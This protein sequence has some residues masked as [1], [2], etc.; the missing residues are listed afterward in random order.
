M[1]VRNLLQEERPQT[2]NLIYLSPEA[3]RLLEQFAYEVEG[4]LKNEYADIPDWAG[5]LVGMVLRIAG[6][7]C[8]ASEAQCVDFLDIPESMIVSGESMAGAIGGSCH[9]LCG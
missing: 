5:K 2:P 3:D 8:R 1:L 6:L 7:L 9:H 4:K